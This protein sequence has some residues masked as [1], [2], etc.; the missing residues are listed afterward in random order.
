MPG[1]VRQDLDL[2]IDLA[3]RLGLPWD[4]SGPADVFREM[5]S[6]MPSL[7]NITW[8]RVEREGSVTYPAD[9][10]D[11]PGNEIIFG[12][13]FPTADGRGQLVPTDLVPP[14][15]LPDANYPFVLTTGRLLEHWHTGAMT[16]RAGVLEAQ[17]GTEI[18]SMHPRD[19][20]RLGFRQG[21][22]VA[23]ET[24]RGRVEPIL[25]AD[26]DV[27]EGMIFMP[28]CF[29]EAPANFLTNPQLDPYGKIPE[30]KFCAA[31][32]EKIVVREAAEQN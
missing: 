14:D 3:R 17:E 10:P 19:M 4:Y 31:K 22:R 16:R 32:V 2:I 6:V 29:T 23:V 20:A 15:E 25:R 30:F 8:E 21:E 18:V 27:T 13:G 26:R 24:R 7:D 28:F 9:F 5:A 11:K 12:D 1:D